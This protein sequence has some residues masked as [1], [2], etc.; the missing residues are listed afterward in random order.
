VFRA[1][2]YFFIA[3]VAISVIKAVLGI[4]GN[5][6]GS[7]FSPPG[8][9]GAPGGPSAPGR[10]PARPPVAESLQKDPVCGTFVAPSTAFQK[11]VDGKT[12]YFCSVQCRDKFRG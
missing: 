3:V 11:A 8:G 1:V 4:V 6:F 2:L 10:P 9:V 7:I 5:L 12:Y